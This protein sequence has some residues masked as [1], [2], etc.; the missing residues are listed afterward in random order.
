VSDDELRDLERAVA[1][2]GVAERLAYAR[3]LERSGRDDDALEA[4]MPSSGSLEARRQ[5][6]RWPAW[7]ETQA[8]RYG[9]RW[10]DTAPLERSPRVRWSARLPA[11][12]E[13]VGSSADLF[14]SPL[15]VF[16]SLGG[17]RDR[18]VLDPLT[19][20]VRA[21]WP[22]GESDPDAGLALLGGELLEPRRAALVARDLVTG[23]SRELLTARSWL[24]TE[25]TVAQGSLAVV[26]DGLGRARVFELDGERGPRESGWQLECRGHALS[27]G[28]VALSRWFAVRDRI[29][30]PDPDLG[31][32]VSS[33]ARAT[34]EVLWRRRLSLRMADE[35]GVVGRVEM[36]P[37]SPG[38]TPE[39]HLLV[40]DRAGNELWRRSSAL[41]LAL[42]P[43][44]VVF[45]EPR[46][47]QFLQRDLVFAERATG[48]EHA[49]LGPITPG[50]APAAARERLFLVQS[51]PE[52]PAPGSPPDV[53]TCVSFA[54]EVLWTSAL[55]G[56]ARVLALA[57]LSRRL[58]VVTSDA[59]VLCLEEGPA[60]GTAR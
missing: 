43:T 12:D 40:L 56:N 36:E 14:A 7:G 6:E 15:G 50:H 49:R 29:F 55:D 17:L 60:G 16:A 21:R 28:Y 53:I 8:S 57:P 52:P 34:G 59:E 24:L 51:S 22:R 10:I 23:R 1:T 37:G 39:K 3:A 9:S 48:L 18:V 4:L 58:Y 11:A 20:S 46:A 42:S 2:G 31:F 32:Q 47:G 5:L 19:G 27:T 25:G 38:W 33:L 13:V 30:W 44:T 45:S 35:E 54:G 41:P 26:P